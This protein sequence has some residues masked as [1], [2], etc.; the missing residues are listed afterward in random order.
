M[1]ERT[2]PF[3]AV[4]LDAAVSIAAVLAGCESYI[5]AIRMYRDATSVAIGL[6]ESKDVI[7]WVRTLSAS[8]RKNVLA[9]RTFV[10]PIYSGSSIKRTDMIKEGQP[11]E[12]DR[13]MNELQA[14][15]DAVRRLGGRVNVTVSFEL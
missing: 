12:R 5:P 3:E 9:G 10:Q 13:A 14:A 7:D 8:T 1:T 15:A 2:I 4:N 6:R 11:S